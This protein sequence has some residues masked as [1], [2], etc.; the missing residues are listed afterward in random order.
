MQQYQYIDISYKLL[1]VELL[2]QANFQSGFISDKNPCHVSK[3]VG[4]NFRLSYLQL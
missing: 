3:F 2:A 1:L 4:L